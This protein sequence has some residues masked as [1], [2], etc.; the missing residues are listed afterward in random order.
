VDTKHLLCVISCPR[1]RSK[2]RHVLRLPSAF[3][4]SPY[5]LV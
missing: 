5:L 3:D 2:K 4:A 1:L